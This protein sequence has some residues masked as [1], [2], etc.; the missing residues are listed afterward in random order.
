MTNDKVPHFHS[1][2]KLQNL[3]LVESGVFL[4]TYARED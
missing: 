3:P 1:D 4:Y 2:I